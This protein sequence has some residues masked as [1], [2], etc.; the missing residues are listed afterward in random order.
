MLKIFMHWT[1]L[2]GITTKSI[3]F[4]HQILTFLRHQSNYF[5]VFSAYVFSFFSKFLCESV[6]LPA[7]TQFLLYFQPQDCV[8]I[9]IHEHTSNRG[10]LGVHHSELILQGLNNLTVSHLGD[11][12]RKGCL[13]FLSFPAYGKFMSSLSAFWSRFMSSAFT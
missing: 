1:Y 12:P 9:H 11:F 4:V 6:I 3:R 8:H 2:I 13:G 7:C 5:V 10:F